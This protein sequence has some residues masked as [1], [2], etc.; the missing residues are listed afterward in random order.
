MKSEDY[1]EELDRLHESGI[2]MWEAAP[3]LREK[4][5]QI[6]LLYCNKIVLDWIKEREYNVS[7]TKEA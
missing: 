3:K 1:F 6:P 4:H 7:Y 5:A 2:N